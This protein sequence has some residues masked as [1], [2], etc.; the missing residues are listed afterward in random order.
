MHLE[1]SD[2]VPTRNN[3]PLIDIAIVYL[4]VLYQTA[5]FNYNVRSMH[6]SQSGAIHFR[7]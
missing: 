7:N 6:P 4:F 1:N 3:K 2:K 5:A